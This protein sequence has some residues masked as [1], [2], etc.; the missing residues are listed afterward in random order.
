MKLA[1]LIGFLSVG[2]LA[3]PRVSA[4]NADIDWTS[5][6]ALEHYLASC[7]RAAKSSERVLYTW[8]HREKIAMLV[9]MNYRQFEIFNN[10]QQYAYAGI[11]ARESFPDFINNKSFHD[12]VAL[13]K[14]S[15][16]IESVLELYQ[17]SIDTENLQ[18]IE[19]LLKQ[20]EGIG[21]PNANSSEEY[22]MSKSALRAIA[23]DKINPGFLND[24]PYGLDQLISDAKEEL[25]NKDL[26]QDQRF[27]YH[28]K[29]LGYRRAKNAA[30]GDPVSSI[31]YGP[32]VYLGKTPTDYIMHFS[33][34]EHAGLACNLDPQIEDRIIDLSTAQKT[35]VEKAVYLPPTK[36]NTGFITYPTGYNELSEPTSFR[37]AINRKLIKKGT[38]FA[39][40]GS[41][42]YN[43]AGV[44]RPI[45]LQDFAS[46]DSLKTMLAN[47]A[48]SQG[49]LYQFLIKTDENAKQKFESR[50]GKCIKEQPTSYCGS[51][52]KSGATY[53]LHKAFFNKQQKWCQSQN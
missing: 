16:G 25:K 13:V 2:L 3:T 52:P 35:L 33:T 31:S 51:F 41:I 49:A 47:D 9:S 14:S 12:Y 38:V 17:H 40:F 23:L 4:C 18:L 45:Q 39:D 29:L 20:F 27:K 1:L 21:P 15:F 10:A 50:F 36:D 46:C 48:A 22:V 5:G 11:R 30:A 53:K 28:G 7:A 26:S 34:A 37:I 43:Q 32:A 19:K 44:C 42:G 6:N 24:L 8:G